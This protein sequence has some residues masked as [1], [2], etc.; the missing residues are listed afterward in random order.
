MKIIFDEKLVP[1]LR[2]KYIVLELDTIIQPKMERPITLHALIDGMNM[3]VLMN[4]PSLSSKHQTMVEAYK[5]SQWSEAEALATELR[6]SWNEEL[7]EFYDIVLE[8]A[9]E[10]MA[11]GTTWDGI[12][13]TNPSEE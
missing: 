6:G 10:H 12:R 1:D 9:R 11:S 5:G 4:L 13:H 3:N 8:T 2:T 7:D